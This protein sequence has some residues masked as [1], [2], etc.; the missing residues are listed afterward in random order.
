MLKRKAF[1]KCCWGRRTYVKPVRN[2]KN[3]GSTINIWIKFL[4]E[5]LNGVID[6][7]GNDKNFLMDEKNQAYV[8]VLSL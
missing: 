1:K 5:L 3:G 6:V 7:K 8:S 4:K 2:R